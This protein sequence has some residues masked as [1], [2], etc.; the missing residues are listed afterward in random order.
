VNRDFNLTIAS[1]AGNSR[2]LATITSLQDLT[3]R[4]LY[5]GLRSLNV[6]AWFQSMH[7]QIVDAVAARDAALVSKLWITDLRYAVRIISDALVTL[8]EVRSVNLGSIALLPK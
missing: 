8:P 2:L 7:S 5:L 1:A 6:S 4:V 3:L